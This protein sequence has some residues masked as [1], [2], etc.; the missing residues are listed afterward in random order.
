MN[1]FY[2]G[3]YLDQGS[4][5]SAKAGNNVARRR[6]RAGHVLS[7]PTTHQGV[8]SKKSKIDF[9]VQAAI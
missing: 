8:V 1:L 6:A 7:L 2:A 3:L 9:D 4:L 5:V